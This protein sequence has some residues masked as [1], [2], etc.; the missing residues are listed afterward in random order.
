MKRTGKFF[1]WL[2][3]SLPLLAFAGG[4]EV[5]VIY[6][7]QMPGS[8]DVAEHYAAMRQVPA[9]QIFSL[10]L[11][12]NEIMSRSEFTESLQHPLMRKLEANG[13]WKFGKVKIPTANGQPARSEIRVV[14]SKIRYAVLCYGVPL[15][16][17]ATSFPE[18]GA[19]QIPAELRRNEASVDSELAWLPLAR[20]DI[21]L[22]GPMPNPFYAITNRSALNC[23]NGILLV[24]RLDGPTP[25]I[26]RGL[27]DKTM[28][29][30]SNGFWGRAY[31][32][33]R[34]LAASETNYFIG[35]A[36][37]LATANFCRQ[38][39]FDT[40]TDTNAETWRAWMPASQIAFYAGWYDGTA[41]APFAGP[42]A[43]F[44]PGAFAYH[45]YSFSADT[46]RSSN[47]FWCGPLLAA[48]ATC[49]MGCVY[50][51]YLQFSPNLSVFTPAFLGGWT[52]GEAAWASQ[53]ALSWQNTV[54]GDP[55]YEPFK[56]NPQA[57]HAEL[58]ARHDPLV[59]WSLNRL[60]NLDLVRGVRVAQLT[61]FLEENPTTA[62]SAVLTEKLA[63]LY[64]Q[65]GKPSSAIEAWQRA[66]KLN[67]S[68][69]QRIRLHR[70]L[71][72]KLLAD[73]HDV[74]AAENWRQ[75]IADSPGYSDIPATKE[76]LKQLEQKIAAEKK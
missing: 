65:L 30:E 10:T 47:R 3:L 68:P 40:E 64:N 41:A 76:R 48:G 7:P 20:N 57:L 38:S 74:D 17:A 14:E 55:L 71:A 8:K 62:Q 36:W 39:G 35:D 72:E 12:T 16:V 37:M 9:N 31:I 42:Q 34:G 59:E 28:A 5:V 24:A 43:E 54:I 75:L 6:N 22:T 70:V 29:A 67:P 50:E 56:K 23:T 26:A 63:Q 58:E 46:L 49:T 51:P 13:L 60:M 4:E 32:D 11:T 44:M 18:D 53:I 61:T 2:M 25:E 15:K 66:L 27:V 73:G 52:F 69:Q 1:T 45:L 21:I 19:R 33:T